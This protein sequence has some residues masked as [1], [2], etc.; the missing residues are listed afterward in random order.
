MNKQTIK[1]IKKNIQHLNE[2]E[3]EEKNLGIEWMNLE[4][5]FSGKHKIVREKLSMLRN[6]QYLQSQIDNEILSLA[7]LL[8]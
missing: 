4:R 6:N 2:L 7:K 8:K 1:S 5:E 3:R